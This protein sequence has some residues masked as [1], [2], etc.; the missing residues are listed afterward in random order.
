MGFN[1]L[2]DEIQAQ[3]GSMHLILYGAASPKEGVEDM[4]LFVGRNAG[5]AVGNSNLHG[6]LFAFS[7]GVGVDTHP[8]AGFGA[9]LD[10]VVEEILERMLQC[11]PVAEHRRQVGVDAAIHS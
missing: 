5:P 2:L 4:G 1:Y 3:T 8:A 11:Q 9:L 7:R 6:A 10:S